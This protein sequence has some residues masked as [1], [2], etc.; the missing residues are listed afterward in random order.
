MVYN[1]Q[2]LIATIRYKETLFKFEK[3]SAHRKDTF[4]HDFVARESLHDIVRIHFFA[5]NDCLVK[6]EK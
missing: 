6:S 2:S 3:I 4:D 1:S 5:V